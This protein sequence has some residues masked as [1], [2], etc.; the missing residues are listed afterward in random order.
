MTTLREEI[1]YGSP[2]PAEAIR[3][4]GRQGFRDSGYTDPDAPDSLNMICDLAG[5]RADR[6]AVLFLRMNSRIFP[7]TRTF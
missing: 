6:P 7:N 1:R 5:G 3:L 2:D 4:Y